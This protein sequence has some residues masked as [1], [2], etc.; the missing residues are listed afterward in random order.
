MKIL[1]NLDINLGSQICFKIDI[2]ILY[3][4][5][6]NVYK[7]HDNWLISYQDTRLESCHITQ[8]YS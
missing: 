8:F 7:F 5:F 1:I 4:L 2:Y 3:N 6:S